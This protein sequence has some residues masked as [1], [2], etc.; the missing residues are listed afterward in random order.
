MLFVESRL[1]FV[2]RGFVVV[3]EDALERFA[4]CIVAIETRLV[5]HRRYD[6]V[7]EAVFSIIGVGS[8]FVVDSRVFR[9]FYGLLCRN[10]VFLRTRVARWEVLV[11]RI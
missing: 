9:R 4:V 3:P 7:H 11:A 8:F 1:A 5:D 6:A 2:V 10:V